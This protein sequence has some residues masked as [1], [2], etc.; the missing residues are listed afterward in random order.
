M[1]ASAS[2]E[3]ERNEVQKEGKKIL[4]ERN[5]HIVLAQKYGWEAV[6]CYVVEPLAC[7]SDDE[8][9]RIRRAVK[10]NKA[11]KADNRRP[12]KP[13]AQLIG[14]FQQSLTSSQNSPSTG[15]VVVPASKQKL[16]LTQGRGCFR[17]GRAGHFAKACRAQPQREKH[18][19][20]ASQPCLNSD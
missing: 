18:N 20:R 9:K 11:L 1:A 10:E 4:E 13:R 16:D 6:D 12:S 5:K 19:E 3:A 17:C 7:D 2:D 8:K 15:R 14:R